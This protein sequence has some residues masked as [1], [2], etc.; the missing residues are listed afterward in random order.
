MQQLEALA[1]MAPTKEEEDELS[2]YQ[3]DIDE[4]SSAEKFVKAILDIPFAFSRIRVML[5]KETFE[6]E[7]VHLRKSFAMLEVGLFFFSF[8]K[9]Q[10][11]WLHQESLLIRLIATIYPLSCVLFFQEA[12]KELRSSRLFF[13]LLEAVLKTGNRMNVGT[14]RGGARAFKLDTLLKLADVKGTDGKT[15]L[16][17]FVVQEIIRSEGVT[18]TEKSTKKSKPKSAEE[19]EEGYRAMGLDIVS[20]LSAELCNVKKTA[21]VDLD[22]LASSVSNLTEGLT[23]LKNLIEADLCGDEG[24]GSFVNRM[25]SFETDAE[26][27]IRELKDEE[28]RV[29]VHVR[30]MTEY[31]HGSVS[32]VDEANPL[33]IFVI[34]RDFL[35]MLD[36]VCGEVRSSKPYPAPNPAIP[37]R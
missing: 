8:S 27:T 15:S 1:K 31:Y 20:G 28:D 9:F 11:S 2:K 19:Q 37:F 4:L 32:K 30:E 5:Y 23:R 17:H 22:V 35:G 12:C 29:V 14:V 24:S 13:R 3:G 18:A 16:L 25:R 26:R 6:D 21:T 36:R 10:P 34:V 33:G 7:V